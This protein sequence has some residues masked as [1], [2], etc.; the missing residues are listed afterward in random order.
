MAAQPQG[1]AANCVDAA[2]RDFWRKRGSA[3]AA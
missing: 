2:A 3:N 1:G